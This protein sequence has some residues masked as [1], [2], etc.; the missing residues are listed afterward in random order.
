MQLV[1]LLE[2]QRARLEQLVPVLV[3]A[4]AA[5]GAS[6]N[7]GGGLSVDPLSQ[8][9]QTAQLLPAG[10]PWLTL[11]SG[12]ATLPPTTAPDAT[13]SA[14][15]RQPRAVLA[16][17]AAFP[18][19]SP[20]VGRLQSG[21]GGGGSR[22]SG[23][24]G[25][26]HLMMCAISNCRR[27]AYER[28]LQGAKQQQAGGALE[29]EQ[30]QQQQQHSMLLL[31]EQVPPAEGLDAGIASEPLL[32]IADP[33]LVKLLGSLLGSLPPMEAAKEEATFLP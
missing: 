23:E 17:A 26:E 9:L 1:L 12:S 4:E 22:S 5:Q 16:A 15:K 24:S 8:L 6:S 28:R 29:R 18:L 30:Q 2:D 14:L 13:P 7:S 33:A 25:E 32:G 19:H 20:S 3:A 11:A 31:P 21:G 27:C 10:Q